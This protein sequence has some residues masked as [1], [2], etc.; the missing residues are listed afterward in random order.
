MNPLIID[1]S[2]DD[3]WMDQLH[4]A[5]YM[6]ALG[7]RGT[8]YVCPGLIGKPGR[9]TEEHLQLL[10]SWGHRIAN[11]TWEHE[12]P[13]AIGEAKTLEGLEHARQWLAERGWAADVVALVKGS[14]GGGWSEAFVAQVLTH[15]FVG[16]RDVRFKSESV[17]VF[18]PRVAALEMAD[19][20]AVTPG[21]N[22][23]Y[24]HNHNN[25]QESALVEFLSTI[26]RWQE[27]G[28]AKVT[29]V[30]SVGD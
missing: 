5:R 15:G 30:D 26:A 19:V 24:F 13:R 7:L 22:A 2:F 17:N 12:C 4:W 6:Q 10:A 27:T 28:V 29:H 21:L 8:F 1:I 9:L 23:F 25:V 18:A 20:M 16:M 3:G 11:H 14:R